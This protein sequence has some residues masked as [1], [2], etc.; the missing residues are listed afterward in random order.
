MARPA[1][2]DRTGIRPGPTATTPAPR[3]GRRAGRDGARQ[4]IWWVAV[5]ALAIAVAV[6]LAAPL[7]GSWYAF[8]DWAG[9]GDADWV[10]MQ[11]FKEIIGTPS[12]RG[13][14]L[15]TFKLAFLFV[16]IVN[17]LG[18]ALAIGL[19]RLVRTR[20]VLRALFFLPVAMSP[21]AIAFIWQYVFQYDGPL[22]Q[23]LD[24]VGLS[25]WK[26]AWLADPDW[27]LW[28][29]L[30]VLVWQFTGLSMVLF[31]AG[32]QTV[33]DDVIEASIV[34]GAT[35]WRRFRTI[36]FP[37]LAPSFTV[38]ATLT[39]ITGLRV[40]DQVVALTGGGPVDSSETLSTQVWKQ[41]WVNGRFGYGAALALILTLVVAVLAIA[42]TMVLRR[43]ESK[44]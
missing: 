16:V 6:H 42:Q 34:D 13:A 1:L 11:N 35:P 9:S 38:S 8:T 19:N 3:S 28:T 43:R 22:N 18:L 44:V 36:V 20:T 30:V 21:V 2:R 31:L 26:H 14:L 15:N 7:A 32:L 10:G 24:A 27:A 25:D 23:L 33:P 41:T 5:P 40:F 12:T 4:L 37:L 39:L 17:A 29:V